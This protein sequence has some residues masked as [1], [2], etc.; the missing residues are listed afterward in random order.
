MWA[1][2][3]KSPLVSDYEISAS[4]VEGLK[5]CGINTC[6]DILQSTMYLTGVVRDGDSG[7]DKIKKAAVK[8]LKDF[9]PAVGREMMLKV[10][11]SLDCTFSLETLSKHAR[12]KGIFKKYA[13][14]VKLESVLE[15]GLFKGTAKALIQSSEDAPVN[16][17]A[18]FGRELEVEICG[19]EQNALIPFVVVTKLPSDITM[20]EVGAHFSGCGESTSLEFTKCKTYLSETKHYTWVLYGYCT[21]IMQSNLHGIAVAMGVHIV[22]QEKSIF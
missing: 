1:W 3:T 14:C 19:K 4:D 18:F 15:D 7:L 13:K 20:Q 10:R 5:A 2:V 17:T 21:S 16:G 22:T 11:L 9:Y 12:N 6:K 8:L